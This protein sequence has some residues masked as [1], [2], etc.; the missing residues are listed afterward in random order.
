MKTVRENSICVFGKNF[1]SPHPSTKRI[2]SLSAA[3]GPSGELLDCRR[4]CAFFFVPSPTSRPQGNL[5]IAGRRPAQG[6]VGG[7][8]F[9]PTPI[10]DFSFPTSLG[11][12]WFGC[13]AGQ[14]GANKRP[15]L[16]KSVPRPRPPHP[17][18]AVHVHSS[19]F[20]APADRL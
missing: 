12:P 1:L 8:P 11:G 20:P 13:R 3:H 16:Q 14:A 15:G 5:L 6:W 2:S 4:P 9:G 10:I 7:A 18:C 17:R 19:C